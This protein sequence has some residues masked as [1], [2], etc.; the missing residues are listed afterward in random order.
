GHGRISSLGVAVAGAPPGAVPAAGSDSY[1]SSREDIQ[2]IPAVFPGISEF[3]AI[4]QARRRGG[5]IGGAGWGS[6]PAPPWPRRRPLGAGAVRNQF[7][8]QWSL[9]RWTE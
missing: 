8:S 9:G 1:L 3:F 5:R 6:G 2:A 4:G 7:T